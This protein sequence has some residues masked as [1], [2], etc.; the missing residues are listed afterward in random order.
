MPTPPWTW[1]APVVVEVA[2]VVEFIYALFVNVNDPFSNV[3]EYVVLSFVYTILYTVVISVGV[4]KDCH[5]SP[6]TEY[7]KLVPVDP[8]PPAIHIF[9]PHVT[10]N[11]AYVELNTVAA[12]VDEVQL[13]PLEE[14]A[15]IFPPLPVAT[16]IEPFHA[17][18]C[19]I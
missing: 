19:P 1:S 8:S 11:A 15:I 4:P 16:Q 12:F 10:F 18:D 17:I 3:A 2:W 9:P 7:A 13:N 14:Y 5:I 6:S